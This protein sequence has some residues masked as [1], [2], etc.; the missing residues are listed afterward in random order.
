M[1]ATSTSVGST[2]RRSPAE[3][4][5]AVEPEEL[6]VARVRVHELALL[7]V[8]DADD[9][10]GLRQRVEDDAHIGPPPVRLELCGADSPFIRLRACMPFPSLTSLFDVSARSERN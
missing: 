8:A 5:V 3:I 2:V 7:V 4:A 10:G 1:C 9:E 6:A